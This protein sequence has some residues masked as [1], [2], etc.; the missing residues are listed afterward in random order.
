MRSHVGDPTVN[1]HLSRSSLSGRK[2]SYREEEL[3]AMPQTGRV[4]VITGAYG[5]IGSELARMTLEDGHRLILLGRSDEKL[6]D[7][8][9]SLGARKRILTVSCD[10]AQQDDVARAV[11]LGAEKFGTIDAVVANAGQ[12]TDVSLIRHNVAPTAWLDMINTNFVGVVTCAWETAPYLARSEGLFI[13][14]GSVTSRAQ[15]DLYGVTKAAAS[16][17]GAA[18]R[19]ELNAA[20]VRVTVVSPALVRTDFVGDSRRANPMLTPAEVG[21]VLLWLLD[22]PGN[23]QVDEIAFRRLK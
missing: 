19:K 9:S 10:V 1:Q 2:A 4:V 21:E 15:V 11:R 17:T 12:V 5:G 7:L 6:A 16:A 18:I 8:K 14:I 3:N 23:F 22:R 20:G 13:I